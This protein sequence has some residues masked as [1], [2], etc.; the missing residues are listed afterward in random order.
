MI[1]I[2]ILLEKAKTYCIIA[3]KRIGFLSAKRTSIK[4]NVKYV[5]S[6]IDF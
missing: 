3:K 2:G 5:K 1:L 4:P 6:T